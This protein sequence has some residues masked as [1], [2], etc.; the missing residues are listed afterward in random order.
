M[1]EGDVCEDGGAEEEAH[2]RSHHSAGGGAHVDRAQAVPAHAQS[3]RHHPER[4][5]GAAGPAVHEEHQV[6]NLVY[7]FAASGRDRRRSL[8]VRLSCSPQQLARAQCTCLADD[9]WQGDGWALNRA[10]RVGWR[11]QHRA[12][13]AIQSAWRG[14]VAQRKYQHTRKSII[15]TQNA[16]RCR[17]AKR[18]LRCG[19]SL[20]SFP[21]G[22]TAGRSAA[23]SAKA[24]CALQMSSPWS[25]VY[26]K[27]MG[28]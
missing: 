28:F 22:W 7:S 15:M 14:H 10:G 21:S 3:H 11:R 16:W 24:S 19:R 20:R 27:P 6:R 5:P 1:F 9:R 26:S 8:V 13:L 17:M 12:A 4:L 25:R 23:C 2:P 18:K